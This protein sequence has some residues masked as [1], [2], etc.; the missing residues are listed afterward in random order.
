MAIL[1]FIC[2]NQNLNVVVHFNFDNI[3]YSYVKLISGE[4]I[5]AL[6]MSEPNGNQDSYLSSL[7]DFNTLFS[8]HIYHS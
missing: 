6:A 5:G 3:V 2:K 4:H 8:R 1:V 7:F